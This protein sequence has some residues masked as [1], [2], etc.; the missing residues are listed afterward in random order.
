MTDYTTFPEVTTQDLLLYSPYDNRYRLKSKL[1]IE[2]FKKIRII[3]QMY[4][5]EKENLKIVINP[6]SGFSKS[7]YILS[8]YSGNGKTTF[9]NWFKEEIEKDNFWFDII[10]LIEEGYGNRCDIT[11]L[12]ECLK[13]KLKENLANQKTL[14]HIVLHQ[15]LFIDYFS[16][17]ILSKICNLASETKYDEIDC[18][19]CLDMM[20]YF[21]I[22]LLYVWDKIL[23]FATDSKF[24]GKRSFT[25]CFDNL[26]EIKHESLN[27]AIW[28][29]ILDT[30]SKIRRIIDKTGLTFD[31]DHRVIFLFVF[32]EA[33][34][35]CSTA[36]LQDRIGP[37][38][39]LK[40]FIYT[41]I[42]REIIEM[43]A[44]KA[45]KYLSEDDR[46]LRRI[47]QIL[48][49][50]KVTED[51]LLPLFNYDYRK[52]SH[53]IIS[54]VQPHS[55]GGKI[56]RMLELNENEYE[57]IPGEYLNG[58][59]GI[60]IN[61]FIRFLAKENFL[62]KL[63][64]I[65]DLN[66][67]IEYCSK[68]R[69][70]LT[71]FSNLS[72][73]NGFPK[74]RKELAEIPPQPFSLLAAYRS[75]NEIM[76]IDE[77]FVK[78]CS[79]IDINKSSWAHLVT[80]YG[81]HPVKTTYN[82]AFNFDYEDEILNKIQ[83]HDKLTLSENQY[84]LNITISLNAAAYI[85]LR[86]IITHFE[87]ISAYKIRENGDPWYNYKPLFLATN[88]IIEDYPY[89]EFENKIK[90]VYKI[91]E[92][93][94][95]NNYNYFYAVFS[96]MLNFNLRSFCRS[97]YIFK[98]EHHIPMKIDNEQLFGLYITRLIST[99]I[100]YLENFRHYFIKDGFSILQKKISNYDPSLISNLYINSIDRFNNFTLGYIEKYIFLLNKVKDPS[101]ESVVYSLNQQIENA[102]VNRETWIRIV[103]TDINTN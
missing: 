34:F 3:P 90:S 18:R 54:L 10:N 91:V 33:N 60:L 72:F 19:E 8:G 7:F 71:L 83:N 81:K 50:E 62:E 42:G 67:S 44:S 51:I 6:E 98:G 87:Y 101:V 76:A 15:N 77:F 28:D 41:K 58:K 39:D 43:R 30:S 94:Y 26:D 63:A 21:A 24:S 49:Y 93:Y 23:A 96:K 57:E 29:G 47:L 52:I 100:E 69:L 68:T 82:Y 4:L 14:K 13:C 55:E 75:C 73:P 85:F 84:I 53:A 25:F 70:M 9:V 92:S 89:W 64:P 38:T 22:L 16:K 36:Q 66:H 88:I 32:R 20:D 102:K 5:D 46:V 103:N 95:N 2:H 11:L 56:Y 48:S 59:R 79:L 17:P 74:N 65:R 78:L 86:Y 97:K 31:F 27:P 1:S 12:E 37:I 40:R 80:I 35:A 61:A 45:T 99:H